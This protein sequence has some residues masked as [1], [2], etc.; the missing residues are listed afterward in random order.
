MGQNVLVEDREGVLEIPGTLTLFMGLG[1][2]PSLS[3]CEGGPEARGDQPLYRTFPVEP[4]VRLS[5][6][7]GPCKAPAGLR[8]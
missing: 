7:G 1:F 2:P 4:E 8:N 6:F 5:C 3:D